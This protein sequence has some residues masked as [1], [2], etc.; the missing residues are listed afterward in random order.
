MSKRK[1][2]KQ[3]CK[4]I[5]QL[6]PTE[7]VWQMPFFFA[8]AVGFALSIAA[9]YERMDLGLIAMIGIM[10]FVYTTNTPIYHRM[11]V[12]M[13]CSFGLCLS[14]LIGLCTHFFPAFSPLIIGLVAMASSILIRYYNIGAPGYFFFVFSC[15][16]AS[17]FPFPSKDY[18]FLVGLICI[19][20][21]IANIAAF[22]YS[23][24]V[25][26]IFKNSPP[27][28]VL[29]NGNLGFDIIFVDSMIIAF[30]VGFA[31]FL[32]AFLEL[33]RSYWVAVSTTVILQGANLKS[34]WIKQLQRILGTTVGILFAW[35]LLKIKFTPLEFVFLMMFLAFI[36]EFLVVRN[37]ALTVIF[38]TPYVTYLAEA[39][40][41]GNLSVDMLIH[42]RLQ[43]IIIGSLLGLLGGFVI[44][45]PYLRKYFEYIAKYIFR[46]RLKTK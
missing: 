18:I 15:L 39:A 34:V 29:Q 45:K 40:S 10:A 4:E 12:T 13:C 41:F 36:I 38:L 46:V 19:G 23:I 22:L 20:G 44:H 17:F 30:F 25:I 6:N 3:Q 24:S 42:A 9:Y 27:K 14:F 2:L 35:W 1:I 21:I 33:D 32:G 28:P 5:I 7:R 26:Y 16:L 31:V 11:A 37:Y 43:D 8:L